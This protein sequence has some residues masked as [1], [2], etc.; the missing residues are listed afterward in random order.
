M[1]E[2]CTKC[3]QRLDVDVEIDIIAISKSL[4]LDHCLQVL[5]E[6]CGLLAI[7]KKDDGTIVL[8]YPEGEKVKWIPQ[9]EDLV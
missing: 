5:C 8:G 9:Y 7:G 4:K 1:A 6:G 3:A 2:F